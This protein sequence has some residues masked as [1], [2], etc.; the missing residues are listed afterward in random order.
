ME[1]FTIG[2]EVTFKDHTVTITGF[3]NSSGDLVQTSTRW[4][5]ISDVS[6]PA[7]NQITVH[8]TLLSF[9]KRGLSNSTLT[10]SLSRN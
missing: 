2:D 8:A 4:V 6:K 5:V 7:W 10:E 3:R 9:A 1:K